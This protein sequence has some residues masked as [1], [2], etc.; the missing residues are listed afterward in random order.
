MNISPSAE[1]YLPGRRSDFPK[2]S[3]LKGVSSGLNALSCVLDYLYRIPQIPPENLLQIARN[4][5]SE[6][7]GR[8][9]TII[10][11]INDSKEFCHFIR[12][13]FRVPCE[14]REYKLHDILETLRYG[15]L[16]MVPFCLK[17]GGHPCS[18]GKFPHWAVIGGYNDEVVPV[19]FMAT[20]CGKFYNFNSIDLEYSNKAIQNRSEEIWY[21]KKGSLIDFTADPET[22]HEEMTYRLSPYPSSY[23]L[24][25]TM[26]SFLP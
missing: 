10:G 14:R 21:R 18:D 4:Y 12:H 6:R 20:H 19:Q 24:A 9:L 26:L 15:G 23:T 5:R 13:Q 8:P 16:V 17:E 1:F 7:D 11:E 25:R 2:T 22:D 3:P